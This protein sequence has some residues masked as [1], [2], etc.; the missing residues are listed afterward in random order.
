M[1]IL[2]LAHRVPYP[3]NKGEKLRTYHQIRNLIENGAEVTLLCPIEK[4]IEVAYCEQLQQEHAECNVYYF[5]VVPKL[6]RYLRAL[7]LNS[8]I[9]EA[10]FYSNA[11]LQNLRAI[12]LKTPFD[13][14]ICT[15]SSM[16]PYVK[17]SR[18]T[19]SGKTKII[20]DFMDLDSNKWTQYAAKSSFW[21]RMVYVREARKV[22][23]LEKLVAVSFDTAFLV[24]EPETRLFLTSQPNASC[25][26][27]TVGNGIDPSEFHPPLKPPK[28]SPPHLLFAGVMDYAPNVDAVMWFFEHVWRLVIA[29]WPESKFTIAG[30]NP[31]PAIQALGENDGI[32]VTGYVTEILPYFHRSSLFVAPFRMARGIQNKILQAMACG[33]PV[34][35]TS[36]GA[37]GIAYDDGRNL[38]IADT[39]SSFFQ[40]IEYLTNDPS[41]Y[42]QVRQEALITINRNYSWAGQLKPLRELLGIDKAV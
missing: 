37:D 27:L 5:K 14:V 34:V 24:A 17:K 21:M 2:Y 8:S 20:M 23:E 32:E 25:R 4:D 42:N 30:M 7:L 15:A 11:L 33:L 31:T 13:A 18:R 39:A 22:A 28:I 40:R 19:L 29:R 10:F 9:S 3:P 38:F 16:A 1:K 36:M 12:P 41:H 26:V 6:C 35:T